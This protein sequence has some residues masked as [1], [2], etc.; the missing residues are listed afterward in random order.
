MRSLK[1]GRA[2]RA[3][4]KWARQAIKRLDSIFHDPGF[5][6]VPIPYVVMSGAEYIATMKK[7]AT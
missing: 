5:L 6:V 4:D 1:K 3:K 2:R 7:A